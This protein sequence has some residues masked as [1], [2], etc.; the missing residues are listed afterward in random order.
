MDNAWLC[1]IIQIRSNTP[2]SEFTWLKLLEDNYFVIIIERIKVYILWKLPVALS[3]QFINELNVVTRGN[4]LISKVL[5]SH[6]YSKLTKFR[7]ARIPRDRGVQC[8]T[9]CSWPWTLGCYISCVLS[10]GAVPPV[11]TS[12]ANLL[13]I[14]SKFVV[15]ILSQCIN[16]LNIFTRGNTFD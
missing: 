15:V 13:I 16:E 4:T 10:M 11:F 7:D 14:L 9:L 8:R 1:N 12:Q 6:A 3:L 5:K 2:E